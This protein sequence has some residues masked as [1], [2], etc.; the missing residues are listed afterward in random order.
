MVGGLR[1]EHDLGCVAH[2]D[3]DVVYHAVTDAVLGAL[4]A[5]DLGSLFPDSD[6]RWAGADSR[7][8]LEEAV[9]RMRDAGFGVGNMDATVIL[10]H[11]R[12]GPHRQA[13]RANLARLLGCEPARVNIKG[14]THE[15]VDALGE[16]RAIA[17]HAVVLLVGEG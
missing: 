4:G 13:M 1:V 8:F 12:I 11:P 15:K 7:V 10:Q 17:C 16:G 3:G 14:K 5:N 6:P 9:G 2:S